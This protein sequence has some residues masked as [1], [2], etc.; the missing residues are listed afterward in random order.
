MKSKASKSIASKSK[1]QL[2]EAIQWQATQC[3]KI[4][5]VIDSSR[6]DGLYFRGDSL[7]ARHG[8]KVKLNGNVIMANAASSSGFSIGWVLK[9]LISDAYHCVIKH[10]TIQLFK[11]ELTL[12]TSLHLPRL[13][14]TGETLVTSCMLIFS[15]IVWIPSVQ[16]L[17]II[18]HSRKEF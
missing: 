13:H 15:T 5:S 9:I 1:M 18:L 17:L 6:L 8:D 10:V 14:M 3:A 16:H 2:S 4:S 11:F 7:T 12:H